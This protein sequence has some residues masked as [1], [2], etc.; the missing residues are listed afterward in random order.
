VPVGTRSRW[1]PVWPVS[2][3]SDGQADTVQL[4]DTPSKAFL[5][6]LG[7]GWNYTRFRAGTGHFRFPWPSF[8]ISGKGV[9]GYFDGSATSLPVHIVVEVPP[10]G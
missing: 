2:L 4:N 6:L 5:H 8:G 1:I 3:D 9:Y 7:I 10:G